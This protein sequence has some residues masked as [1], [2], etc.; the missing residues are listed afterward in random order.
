MTAQ[1]V[2]AGQKLAVVGNSGYTL[3]PGGGYHVHVHITRATR[4]LGTKHSIPVRRGTAGDGR[5]HRTRAPAA[6]NRAGSRVVDRHRQRAVPHR[7][8]EGSNRAGQT[9][10]RSGSSSGEPERSPFR[11]GPGRVSGFRSRSRAV[12]HLGGRNA[13]RTGADRVPY[14]AGIEGGKPAA[15]TKSGQTGRPAPLIA[16]SGDQNWNRMPTCNSRGL[17]EKAWLTFPKPTFPGTRKFQPFAEGPSPIEFSEPGTNCGWFKTLY[18]SPWISIL[19][20][21]RSAKRLKT[22]A[23]KH[24]QNDNDP[25]R[26]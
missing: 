13:Q 3:G 16:S 11:S 21:S 9:R 4:H 18:A 10:Y 22:A 2:E 26:P 6:R 15:D 20:R 8:A 17:L 25:W 19:N 12:A 7:L 24:C 1:R 14:R 23:L 5:R